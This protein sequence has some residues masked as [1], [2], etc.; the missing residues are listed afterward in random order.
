MK[1]T[2]QIFNPNVPYIFVS[3]SLILCNL[4]IVLFENF[5]TNMAKASIL[6]ENMI[7]FP[8]KGQKMFTTSTSRYFM[9][10]RIYTYS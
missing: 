3:F 1:T 2:L 7:N 6:M 8:N 4:D 5:D 10:R 9:Y